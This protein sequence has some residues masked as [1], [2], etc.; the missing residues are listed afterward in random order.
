MI[1]NSKS[2]MGAKSAYI[3]SSTSTHADNQVA[4]VQLA[5]NLGRLGR[6]TLF[7]VEVRRVLQEVAEIQAKVETLKNLG[8]E[9]RTI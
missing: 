9:G 4:L 2:F 3:P 6:K 7:A 8:S 5:E 1:S